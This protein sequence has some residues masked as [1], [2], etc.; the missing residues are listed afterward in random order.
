MSA[1]ATVAEPE[2]I[3]AKPDA[4]KVKD[5]KET[6]QTGFISKQLALKYPIFSR[7]VNIDNS[8]RLVNNLNTL[9]QLD[10]IPFWSTILYPVGTSCVINSSDLSY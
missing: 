6:A 10:I 5:S 7:N 1:W 3:K 8:I 4:W 9:L 2:E